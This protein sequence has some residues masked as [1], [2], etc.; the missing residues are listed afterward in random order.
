MPYSRRLPRI[1]STGRIAVRLNTAQRDLFVHDPAV[2]KNLGHALH[3]APVREGKLALRLSR[4]E[5]E[6]LITAAAKAP[7]PDRQAER[8]MSALLKYLESLLDRFAEPP[9]TSERGGNGDETPGP[10]YQDQG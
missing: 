7:A 2:P 4:E 9:E 3:R 6:A 10:A 5:L 1:P 8:S